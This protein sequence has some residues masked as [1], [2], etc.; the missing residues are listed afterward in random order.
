MVLSSDNLKV[1]TRP[2][3][4]AQATSVAEVTRARVVLGA[5]V[6]ILGDNVQ[7]KCHYF[8]LS[9]PLVGGSPNVVVVSKS[10]Q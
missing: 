8:R 6:S 5:A 3:V 2:R 7:G 4:D 9:N 1:R 10:P